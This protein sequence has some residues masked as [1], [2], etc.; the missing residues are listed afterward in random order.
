MNE[1]KNQQ[2]AKE[3]TDFCRERLSSPAVKTK[4]SKSALQIVLTTFL[5]LT[6]A[7]GSSEPNKSK[8]DK[9]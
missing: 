3:I 1:K 2:L 4:G 6:M 9:V 8:W 5:A 7:T